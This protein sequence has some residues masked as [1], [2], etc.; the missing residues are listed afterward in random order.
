VTVRRQY[1]GETSAASTFGFV[2]FGLIAIDALIWILILLSYGFSLPVLLL[3]VL[4]S[5]GGVLAALG[6]YLA[7]REWNE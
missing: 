5:V 1:L 4:S 3:L 2:A 7:H 6:G